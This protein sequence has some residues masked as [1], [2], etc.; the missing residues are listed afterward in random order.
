MKNQEKN[1]L[2]KWVKKMIFFF[3]ILTM[4]IILILLYSRFIET[5]KLE[6]D[7]Y[8]IVDERFESIHGYKIAHVSDIH[9]GKTTDKEMLDKLIEKINLTKHNKL[10]YRIKML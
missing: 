6:I 9:Y 8:R 10:T 7:E 2:R 4:I 5:K 3:F 1:S